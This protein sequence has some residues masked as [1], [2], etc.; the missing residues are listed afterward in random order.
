MAGCRVTD[1]MWSH[2]SNEDICIYVTRVEK[3]DPNS[4]YAWLAWEKREPNS[5]AGDTSTQERRRKKQEGRR[6]P[7]Y[8]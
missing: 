7:A 6:R 4:M 5:S 2:I 3:L 1:V 8:V